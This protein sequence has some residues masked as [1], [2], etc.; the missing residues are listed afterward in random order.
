MLSSR[1]TFIGKGDFKAR[2][3]LFTNSSVDPSLLSSDTAICIENADPGFDFIFNY[4]FACLI[5]CYGGANSHMAIRCAE[6][7]I[8][9]IIGIGP[10]KYQ[11]LK[12]HKY[13][14]INTSNSTFYS[15]LV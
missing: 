7:G 9:A 5:T 3:Y 1:P 15:S 8:P 6:L 13:L 4:S 11:S 2:I 14:Y 10:S 12:S